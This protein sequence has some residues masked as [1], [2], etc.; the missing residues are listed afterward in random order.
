MK[1]VKIGI[2]REGRVPADKRVPLMPLKCEETAAA[3][4]GVDILI[5]PSPVRSY[6]DQEYQDLVLRC[7]KI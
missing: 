3:F 4:P 6:S 2:I 7:R 5:Q 1:K